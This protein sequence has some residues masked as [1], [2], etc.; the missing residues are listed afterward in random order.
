MTSGSGFGLPLLMQ[1]TLGRQVTL[2]DLIGKGK[3][4]EVWRGILSGENVAVKIF[5]SKDEMSWRRE[6]EIYK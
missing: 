5:L 1:R 2:V 3:Y 4:G 6:T